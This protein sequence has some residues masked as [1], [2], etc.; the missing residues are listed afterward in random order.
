MSPVD[1][2]DTRPDIVADTVGRQNNIKIRP[3]E[4][5]RCRPTMTVGVTRPV[6]DTDQHRHNVILLTCNLSTT[7]KVFAV[8]LTRPVTLTFDVS[9]FKLL[10]IARHVINLSTNVNDV[11]REPQA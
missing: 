1:M 8:R 4:R 11:R 6:F 7:Y 9:T 2:P 3:T 10:C 5:R